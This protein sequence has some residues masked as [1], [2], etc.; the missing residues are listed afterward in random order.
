MRFNPFN[1]VLGLTIVVANLGCVGRHFV[2]DP[3][4][5]AIRIIVA[6]QDRDGLPMKGWPFGA[7]VRREY[8]RSELVGYAKSDEAGVATIMATVRPDDRILFV[9]LSLWQDINGDHDHET[10]SKHRELVSAFY[11]SNAWPTKSRRPEWQFDLMKPG[12][13]DRRE[14]KIDGLPAIHIVGAL[15]T[16]SGRTPQSR[17]RMFARTGGSACKPDKNGRF[18]LTGVPMGEPNELFA[19]SIPLVANEVLTPD[20]TAAKVDVG[21][22]KPA[23]MTSPAP[24]AVRLEGLAEFK[25]KQFQAGHDEGLVTGTTLISKNGSSIL[26]YLTIDDR[27]VDQSIRGSNPLAPPGS[28]YV[29]PGLFSGTEIHYK[30]LDAARAGIALSNIP[31]IEVSEKEVRDI[32]VNAGAV[33]E[34]VRA[35][36]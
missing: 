22:M 34:A 9:G 19:V 13:T 27:A 3:P 28:Y 1:T 20:R 17:A 30:V 33:A 16:E 31:V 12:A 24:F 5:K 23:A 32:T 25:L 36:P 2:D 7:W 18:K 4:A 8:G 6:F 29:L 21:I 14:I 11:E 26:T 10:S 35:I 15:A